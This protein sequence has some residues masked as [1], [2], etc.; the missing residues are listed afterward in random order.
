MMENLFPYLQHDQK[1]S[2][3]LTITVQYNWWFEDGHHRTHSDCGPCCTERGLREHSL[4]CQKMFGDWQ[5]T[6]WTLLVTFCIVIIRC[7]ETFWSF[8]ISVIY[9]I[10]TIVCW[11]SQISVITWKRTPSLQSNSQASLDRWNPTVGNF[12]ELRSRDTRAIPVKSATHNNRCF[13]VYA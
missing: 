3:Y 8:C 10:Y 5:G 6:L 11:W 2:V 13:M 12:I 4:A 1:V 9:R 7:T